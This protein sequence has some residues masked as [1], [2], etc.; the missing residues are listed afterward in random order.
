MF[1]YFIVHVIVKK[2]APLTTF[3]ISECINNIYLE[4]KDLTPAIDGQLILAESGQDRWLF[5][6]FREGGFRHVLI[7]VLVSLC[8][9]LIFVHI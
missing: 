3:G 9:T 6:S 1:I 5:L 2:P 7:V 4:I 8:S